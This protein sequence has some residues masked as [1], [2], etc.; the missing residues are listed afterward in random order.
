MPLRDL[1]TTVWGTHKEDAV[2]GH[3][4]DRL[5]QAISY[6]MCTLAEGLDA[7]INYV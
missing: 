6:A 4:K 7:V 1:C 5:V 2:A 3:N